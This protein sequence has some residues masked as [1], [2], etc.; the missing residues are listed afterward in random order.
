[1]GHGC[2]VWGLGRVFGFWGEEDGDDEGD[3]EDGDEEVQDES[4]DEEDGD[5]EEGE[6][7][8]VNTFLFSDSQSTARLSSRKR[9][10]E[11]PSISA[12]SASGSEISTEIEN[13]QVESTSLVT[14]LFNR[15]VDFLFRF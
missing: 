2:R 1:M 15:M 3:I 4:D 10:H 9:A 6:Q 7:N 8:P 5:G 11:E 13:P 14:N 12:T